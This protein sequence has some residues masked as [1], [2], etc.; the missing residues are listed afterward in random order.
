M[1]VIAQDPTVLKKTQELCQ[2]ILD[3]PNM[4]TLRQNITA[5]L[6]DEGA[7]SQYETVMRKGQALHEKQ[8][9]SQQLSQEEISDFESS[10]DR[11]LANPVASAF[12]DAQEEMSHLR[13]AIQDFVAKTLELGRLPVA[14]D[15]ESHGCCGGGSCGDHDHDHGHE[16]E[17]SHSHGGCGCRH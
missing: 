3:Q 17:H 6:G 11:L 10:R 16:H 14:E 5:F 8:H 9:Q 4:L 7:R 12:L 15:F 13:N 2:S 1:S